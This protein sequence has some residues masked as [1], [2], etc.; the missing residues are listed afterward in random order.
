VSLVADNNQSDRIIDLEIP[1]G[2]SKERLDRY[3]GRLPD[4]GISRTR[5]QKLIE[6]G[7]V[8]VDG[9]PALHNHPLSGGEKITIKVP[10]LPKTE[11]EP[12]EI[13]LDIVYEDDYLLVVNKSAGMVTHPAA[14]NYSGTLVNA[15][16]HHASSLS[17]SHGMDRPGIV[18]RLDKNTSGLIMIAKNDEV[19]VFLQKELKERRI[20]KTYWALVCGHMK[21]ESGSI[22][23]PIGRSLK[24]RKRMTVTNLKSRPA[25]TEYKLLER[26]KLYDLLEIDLKT[27]RTHQ[28]RVHFCH[29]GHPVLGDSE[30][31]GRAKWHKGIFSIDRIL[32]NRALD[33]IDRQALHAMSLEFTHPATGKKL[34]IDSEL[35]DDFKGLLEFLRE[36][37]Q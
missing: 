32:A 37:L 29:I 10:P 25:L 1:S 13:P 11:A 28:I 26:F 24:D 17:S 9:K 23:L 34:K 22:D 14:G 6:S 8:L 18:H 36:N 7:L 31:G 33:M 35:P 15:L 27:G 30:Y 19:H 4:L 21:K 2:I 3:I 20:Q 5:L 12:E 16:L